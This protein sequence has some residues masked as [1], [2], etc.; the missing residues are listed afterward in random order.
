MKDKGFEYDPET[1]KFVYKTDEI[2]VDRVTGQ[3]EV[4]PISENK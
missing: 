2:V 4:R 3:T 1:M